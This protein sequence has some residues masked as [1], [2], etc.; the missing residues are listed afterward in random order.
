MRY[1]GY[2]AYPAQCTTL[3]EC[4]KLR[5]IY[6]LPQQ[7]SVFSVWLQ[8]SGA[9]P[10]SKLS[11]NHTG[12]LR[13]HNMFATNKLILQPRASTFFSNK[14][15][16]NYLR[17]YQTGERKAIL[18]LALP[19]T[20]RDRGCSQPSR[21]LSAAPRRALARVSADRWISIC[22]LLT[23]RRWDRSICFTS[24]RHTRTRKNSPYL[25]LIN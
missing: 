7:G 3:T 18:P 4:F 23:A 17:I 12:K 15:S 25:I 22:R 20:R 8:T 11:K 24:Q 5:A 16:I 6:L 13:V 21:L 10:V 2:A 1:L 19:K 14:D 9:F